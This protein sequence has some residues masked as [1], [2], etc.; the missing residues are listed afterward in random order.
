MMFELLACIFAFTATLFA[1]MLSLGRGLVALFV[2]G[3]FHGVFRANFTGGASSFLFDSA[4]LGLYFAYLPKALEGANPTGFSQ[5]L[6]ALILWPCFMCLLPRQ[7]F[8]VQL[9]GLRAA[10]Y[11]VPLLF[12]GTR[13]K[14]ADLLTLARGLAV[15]NLLALVVGIYL[16]FYG[17]ETL[18]PRNQYTLTLYRTNDVAGGMWHRIPSTFANAASY[19]STMVL[20]ATFLVF[21]L[22]GK[23]ATPRDRLLFVAA[24]FAAAVGV[25]LSACRYP[26]VI[27]G[28][29]AALYLFLTR[30][31]ARKLLFM[32][33]LAGTVGA[34]VVSQP[35]L[36]RFMLLTDTDSV[37]D[38]IQLSA[39]EEFLDLLREYPLG[40]G[41]GR[42]FGTS[43]P[44]FL[45]EYAPPPIGLE[46]EYS[47]ILVEQGLI[48]LLLWVVFLAWV[49]GT[50]LARLDRLQFMKLQPPAAVG[51]AIWGTAFISP[52]LM[53]GIPSAAL[54]M[55]ITGLLGRLTYP[56]V[57]RRHPVPGPSHAGHLISRP[58][59]TAIVSPCPERGLC[60]LIAPE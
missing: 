52:G 6:L 47:R 14:S 17:V 5:F 55:I 27:L 11:F 54:I 29:S 57:P 53:T 21:G 50:A 40:A 2:V 12:I 8:L 51:L 38:R 44:S 56:V 9:V 1:S 33:V 42:A 16:Y 10:I 35:R 48:G 4:V 59:R 20:S 34:L 18:F 7:N 15:L 22:E 37:A 32:T 36:Q 13:C 58:H 41:L 24:I 25:F 30:M 46:N 39:N 28:I 19:G 23:R 60:P 3:Y 45:Q 31:S 49:L 43:I 26:V